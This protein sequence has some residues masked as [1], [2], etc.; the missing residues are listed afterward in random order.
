MTAPERQR[1]V[2]AATNVWH[3]ALHGKWQHA[4]DE[5]SRLQTELGT[6]A[7]LTAMLAWIDTAVAATG[8]PVGGKWQQAYMSESGQITDDPDSVRPTVVWAGRLIRAR[9]ADDETAFLGHVADL[10]EL[11][12]TKAGDHVTELLQ[13][14]VITYQ[15]GVQDGKV[16][17]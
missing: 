5:I 7:L 12:P 2:T 4:A 3:L 1:A 6:P 11:T 17:R 16:P 9:V 15:N 8:L 13:C 14:C 10:A